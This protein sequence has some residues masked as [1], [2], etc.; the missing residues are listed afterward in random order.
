[1]QNK[2]AIAFP[3]GVFQLPDIP[4]DAQLWNF[5]RHFYVYSNIFSQGYQLCCHWG[6]DPICVNDTELYADPLY[7][8]VLQWVFSDEMAVVH[9]WVSFPTPENLS[10][11]TTVWDKV[12]KQAKPDSRR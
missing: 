10:L 7:L 9:P 6:H 3:E 12:V 8:Q 11:N 1:M 4:S 5:T 2:L